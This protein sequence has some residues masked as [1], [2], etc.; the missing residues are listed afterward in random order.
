VTSV[1]CE[2]TVE[3]GGAEHTNKD[4]SLDAVLGVEL[5]NGVVDVIDAHGELVGPAVVEPQSEHAALLQL[6]AERGVDAGR[7]LQPAAGA[8]NHQHS[9]CESGSRRWAGQVQDAAQSV[10]SELHVHGCWQ[11][12]LFSGWLKNCVMF[13]RV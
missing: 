10:S 11:V 5:A 8:G 9:A 1:S 13:A 7:T 3:G 2:G 4:D 12:L 6:A